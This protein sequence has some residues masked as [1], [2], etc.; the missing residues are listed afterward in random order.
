MRRLITSL[1]LSLLCLVHPDLNAADWPQWRGVDGQGHAQGTGYPLKWSETEGVIWKTEIPGRGWSS[2]VIWKNQIWLTMAIEIASSPERAAERMKANKSDQPLTLLDEVKLH[3]VCLD[4]ES[5]RLLQDIEVLTERDPQWVHKLNSYASPSPVIEDGRLYAHFGTFGTVCVDTATN[6]VLWKNTDLKLMHEN[7]PGSSTYL[8]GDHVIF[9][10][11]GSD[12]QFVAALDKA[13]GKVAWKTLRTG[14]MHDNVQFKKNY[15]TPLLVDMNGKS[16]LVSNG[17]DWVYGYEPATGKELWKRSYGML[18]FSLSSRPVAGHGMV[19]YSTGFMK[20]TMQALRYEG[21]SEPEIAWT[22]T[23]GAPTMSSPI[24][25]G[26][27]LYFVNDGGILTCLDAKTGNENYRE[28]LGGNF[29]ASPLFADGRLYFFS[30]E[31]LTHVIAPG[32]SFQKLAESK[33]DGQIMASPAAVDGAI[34][35]RTDKALYRIE[36]SR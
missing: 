15:G 30:R 22:Y 2:P 31:G 36:K 21:L 18:G 35:L 24:L 5:G 11:D 28:R 19:Y 7:G 23:K 17:A 1:S 6:K 3:V 16:T 32:K 12:V 33:L 27:E 26:E 29:N 20:P 4:R 9:N 13:T 14:A 8:A 34:F 10:G 25:V